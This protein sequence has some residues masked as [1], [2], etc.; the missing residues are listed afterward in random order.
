M[1]ALRFKFEF[2]AKPL[3]ILS[4]KV[5][6][7]PIHVNFTTIAFQSLCTHAS[8]VQTAFLLYALFVSDLFEQS[9]LR[10][11]IQLLAVVA[12]LKV[13]SCAPLSILLTTS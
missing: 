13:L 8:Y 7:T 12:P 6:V 4:R 2:Q 9:L 1:A 11:A 3:V 5:I 10:Y